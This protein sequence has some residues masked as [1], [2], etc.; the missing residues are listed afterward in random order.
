[1]TPPVPWAER[2]LRRQ[3][4]LLAVALAV[5]VLVGAGWL[6]VA[7]GDGRAD[8][9][10]VPAGQAY[11]AGGAT[12][13]L[14]RLTAVNTLPDGSR[15]AT[16]AVFVVADVQAELSAF[17]ADD[18]CLLSLHAGEWEFGS[19]VGYLPTDPTVHTSCHRGGSGVVSAA[20]EVPANLLDRVDGVLLATAGA[21]TTVLA[22]R[23]G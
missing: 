4:E 7:A 21:P 5:A 8:Y 23:I 17:A 15:P 22:G 19:Q 9:P 10:T 3:R 2:L 6:W 16:G 11:H 13:T 20:F 18:H 14:T 12:W 1:M